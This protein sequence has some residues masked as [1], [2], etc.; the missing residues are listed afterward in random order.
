MSIVG[1]KLEKPAKF[2]FWSMAATEITEDSEAGYEGVL[3]PSFPAAAT[4]SV[5]AANAFEQAVS[6]A[7]E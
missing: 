4:R 5:P 7:N 3:V 2:L 6:R 1:P